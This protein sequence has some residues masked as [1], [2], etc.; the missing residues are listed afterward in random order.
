MKYLLRVLVCFVL[1]VSPSAFGEEVSKA[2]QVFSEIACQF[3]TSTHFKAGEKPDE[4]YDWLIWRSEREMEVYQVG[5][6]D[7]EAWMLDGA[8]GVMYARILHPERAEVLF[9]A[10]ELRILGRPADWARCSS[11]VSPEIL[12]GALKEKGKQ[13][14]LGKEV[15]VFEGEIAA[16]KWIV[17]WSDEDQI[18]VSIEIE[19]EKCISRTVLQERHE[20]KMQPWERLRARGYEQIGYTELGDNDTDPRIKRIM[21]RMG[22]KCSHKGC[23][24]VCLTPDPARN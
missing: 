24:V 23:S 7:G 9:N 20:L 17:L 18:A 12:N 6:R 10:M 5:T 11:L 3:Q 16:Q 15:K 1:I 19:S 21:S 2:P 13:I 4:Q 14:H 22:I 8:G